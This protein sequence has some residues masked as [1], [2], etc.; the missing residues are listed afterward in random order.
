MVE[1]R[2]VAQVGCGKWGQHILRDLV[3][4]GCRVTVVARSEAS[5]Q[6]A[7]EYGAAEIVPD[8]SLLPEVAGVIVAT[9]T[10]THA[11]V[12]ERVAA[13]GVPIY[14]EK[15]IAADP[16]VADRLAEQCG[17]RL[18]VMEK[19]RYHPG[20]AE[21]ARIARSGELGPALGLALERSSWGNPHR[22]VD[23][24]WIL[25]PHDLSIAR[26]VLGFL[27]EPRTAVAE[28]VASEC[29]GLRMLGGDVPWVSLVYSTRHRSHERTV[30]LYC[31]DGVAVLP[32]PYS[33]VIEVTRYIG[34]P[35][36]KDVP[37]L[38]ARPISNELPLLRQLRAFVEHLAGGP[39]PMS[40]AAE[41]AES[42]RY[43]AAMRELAGL[44]NAR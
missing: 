40:S 43:I 25:A 24:V 8:V 17:D 11:E 29:V 36:T 30:R 41:G 6:R 39:P 19:W 7:R 15:P 34:A 26:E 10:T 14:C 31:R 2:S 28:R 35:V 27:P 23:C 42:V 44:P 37:P 1:G 3:S 5:I 21:L 13:R 16:A 32:G 20:I 4:L 12:I 22:D 9:P 33:E 18:M 38:E